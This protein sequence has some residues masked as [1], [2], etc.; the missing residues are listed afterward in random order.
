MKLGV[1]EVCK[2]NE[3][4]E[5]DTD[6]CVLF[7]LKGV[8]LLKEAYLFLLKTTGSLVIKTNESDFYLIST[9][10]SYASFPFRVMGACAIY[11]LQILAYTRTRVG[12]L[13]GGKLPNVINLSIEKMAIDSS[14][15]DTKEDS[16]ED[17]T[18]INVEK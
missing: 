17:S 18:Y 14:D 7:N 2:V 1:I 13:T 3:E 6:I 9:S 5:V 16:T 12:G 4:T 10:S 15:K 11:A 8:S